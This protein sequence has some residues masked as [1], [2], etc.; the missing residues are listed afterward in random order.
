[1]PLPRRVVGAR[2]VDY[3]VGVVASMPLTCRAVADALRML[4]MGCDKIV[5]CSGAV[6][7]VFCLVNVFRRMKR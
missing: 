2:C 7:P 3:A 5:F 1:M 6:Y 4:I